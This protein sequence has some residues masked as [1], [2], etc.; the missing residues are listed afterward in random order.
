MSNRI[1]EALS[2]PVSC[3]DGNCHYI[4]ENN[5]RYLA[6]K[7]CQLF[8]QPLDDKE[9]REKISKLLAESE[10]WVWERLNNL[11][12]KDEVMGC[13]TKSHFFNLADQIL[14]LLQPKIEEAK[15]DT[16]GRCAKFLQSSGEEAYQKGR[17][18]ALEGD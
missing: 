4:D 2:E 11:S 14:A 15:Q 10:G 6:S 13:P 16:L 18:D 17:Y 12:D 7:I 8:T 5:K 1:E 3:E 9:L